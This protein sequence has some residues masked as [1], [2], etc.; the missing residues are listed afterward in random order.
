MHDVVTAYCDDS[1][2]RE[3]RIV[4]KTWRDGPLWGKVLTCLNRD[5]IVQTVLGGLSP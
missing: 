5:L 4:V 1:A 2:E 3:R